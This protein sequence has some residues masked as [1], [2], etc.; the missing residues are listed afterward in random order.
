MKKTMLGL[1]LLL[2]LSC[3][4]LLGQGFGGIC[5]YA[6]VPD[7][8]IVAYGDS[9]DDEGKPIMAIFETYGVEIQKVWK[10]IAGRTA[11]K[12]ATE[13]ADLWLSLMKELNI[14]VNPAKSQMN[15]ALFSLSF[16]TLDFKASTPDTSQIDA[17]FVFEGKGKALTATEVKAAL[18]K[19]YGESEYAQKVDLSIVKK[20]D[21]DVLEFSLKNLTAEEEQILTSPF[22]KFGIAFLDGGKTFVIGNESSLGRALD[23]IASKSVSSVHPYIKK[24]LGEGNDFLAIAMFPQLRDGLSSAT[25]GEDSGDPTAALMSELVNGAQGMSIVVRLSDKASVFVNV[26]LGKPEDAAMLKGQFWDG[27]AMPMLQQLK[28]MM[29]KA[30][31]DPFP[32]LDSIKCVAQE[33]RV[34]LSLDIVEQDLKKLSAA[35][36]RF[37]EQQKQIEAQRQNQGQNQ[38][39]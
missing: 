4:V 30:L 14:D 6:I 2:S 27:A 36:K 21:V 28:P 11:G 13:A 35:M 20:N 16:G 12:E 34:T 22:R 24:C 37:E 19:V 39:Q 17:I 8:P 15:R 25:G 1:M 9:T 26:D 18:E 29:L 10:G 38:D 7:A 32:L 5:G 31:V 3:S 33:S 23:R